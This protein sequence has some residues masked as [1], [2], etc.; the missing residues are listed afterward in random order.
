MTSFNSHTYNVTSLLGR[1]SFPNYQS[2]RVVVPA[3]QRPFSWE[4]SHVS[5]FWEDVI[6]FHA[7]LSKRSAQ[8]LYFLG[9]IVILPEEDDVKLLDGQQR[10]ATVTVLLAVLR[11]YT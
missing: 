5:A 6:T 4:K 1:A 3:F 8:D 9:P 11:D 2:K 7:Q 10:L